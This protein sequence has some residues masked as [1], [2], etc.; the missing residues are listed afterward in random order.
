[1]AIQA[2]Q[3]QQKR[4]VVIN[5]ERLLTQ[6]LANKKKHVQEYEEA[7]A[8]YKDMASEKLREAYEEAK[9]SLEKNLAKGLAKLADFTPDDEEFSSYLTLVE[10]KVVNL[11]VPKNYEEEYEAAIQMVQWDTRSELELTHAEFNCFIR[12]KWDWTSD[13]FSTTAIYNSKIGSAHG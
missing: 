6:L 12:D 7:L 1:M 8:G 5:K 2:K 9:V 13:F 11:P 4:T 10:S 3:D